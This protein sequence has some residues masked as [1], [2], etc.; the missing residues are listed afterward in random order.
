MLAHEDQEQGEHP[1]GR[2]GTVSRGQPGL[3][4]PELPG[5]RATLNRV[6]DRNNQVRETAGCALLVQAARIAPAAAWPD[7]SP[8]HHAQVPL[9][10]GRPGQ[11]RRLGV[12]QIA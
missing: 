5:M 1:L 3:V 7:R 11:E 9:T 8:A 10:R 12:N 4:L 2:E 6:S